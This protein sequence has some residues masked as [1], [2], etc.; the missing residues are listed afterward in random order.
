LI[1]KALEKRAIDMSTGGNLTGYR[2]YE[3]IMIRL[4]QGRDWEFEFA[5]DSVPAQ[6]V[7]NHSTYGPALLVAAGAELAAREMPCDLGFEIG[8]EAN[9][10]FGAKAFFPQERS[11]FYA[12]IMRIGTTALIIEALPRNGHTIQLDPLQ[13][14]LGDQF[15]HYVGHGQEAE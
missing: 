3:Q 11:T 13:Y 5:G 4:A 14:V 2:D 6:S 12:Q 10:L 9:S 1:Y 15:A 7:F 8:G